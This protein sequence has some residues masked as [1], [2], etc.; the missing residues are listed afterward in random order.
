MNNFTIKNI[1]MNE[2]DF[3]NMVN[4]VGERAIKITEIEKG[5]AINTSC[6]SNEVTV[7]NSVVFFFEKWNMS[8]KLNYN[9]FKDIKIIWRT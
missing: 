6:V 5:I 1:N 3:S 2:E 4:Y 7:H 9:W 8:R